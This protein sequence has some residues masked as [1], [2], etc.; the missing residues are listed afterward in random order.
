MKKKILVSSILLVL[1]ILIFANQNIFAAQT[2]TINFKAIDSDGY[3]VNNLEVAVYQVAKFEDSKFIATDEF[4]MFDIENLSNENI[5]SM[6]EYASENLEYSL[7]K[8][9]N[10]K[11]EFTLNNIEAG[12]YL[13]VQNS[14][15]DYCTM[16]TMFV[17]VPEITNTEINYEITVKP[18][19]AVIDAYGGWEE[20][21]IEP[22]T[23]PKSELPNTGVLN[24]P[25][26]VL[27]I[28]GII[29]FCLLWIIFYSKK[30]V[31]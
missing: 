22:A 29:L 5:V 28:T 10:D 1:F 16:Q 13:L 17:S 8:T 31:K 25:I 26:P 21:V 4:N 12:K 9:T 23:T 19:I 2:G 11:G 3:E 6:Q 18:K 30:K 15:E 7:T 20:D 27:A 14:R 24:W